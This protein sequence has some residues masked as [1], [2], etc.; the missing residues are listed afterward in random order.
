[1][2][3]LLANSSSALPVAPQ[4]LLFFLAQRDNYRAPLFSANEVFCS[5]DAFSESTGGRPTVVQCPLGEFDMSDFIRA[6]PGLAKPE[7][8]IVKIDAS[9]RCCPRNLFK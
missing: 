9:L 1:M 3:S 8:L 6:T 4:T 2:S 5:P 7:L